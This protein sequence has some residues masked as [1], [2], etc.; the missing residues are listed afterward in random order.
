VKEMIMIKRQIPTAR[1]VLF[2]PSCTGGRC[3]Q[4][5][6]EQRE[7]V[8]AGTAPHVRH[9]LEMLAQA[10]ANL[11]APWSGWSEGPG[12]EAPIRIRDASGHGAPKGRN[13]S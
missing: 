12:Q 3:R 2:S 13:F 8:K 5:D 10:L 9:A 6:E 7:H 11:L 1:S 4:A